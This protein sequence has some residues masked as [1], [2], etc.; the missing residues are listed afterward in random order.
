MPRLLND[1]VSSDADVGSFGA[2]ACPQTMPR[3]R[4]C[5][6]RALGMARYLLEHQSHRLCLQMIVLNWFQGWQAFDNCGLSIFGGLVAYYDGRGAGP[7][8]QK[9]ARRM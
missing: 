4:L 6:L 3:H 9:G 5:S 2:V 8:P 1:D 7:A